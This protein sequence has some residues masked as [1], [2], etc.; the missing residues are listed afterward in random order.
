M[1]ESY[2]DLVKRIL[3]DCKESIAYRVGD[4]C[5]ILRNDPKDVLQAMALCYA[6]GVADT[7]EAADGGRN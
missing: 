2:N 6:M 1:S 7:C 4:A 5:K 3:A